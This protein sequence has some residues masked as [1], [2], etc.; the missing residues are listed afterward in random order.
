MVD[1]EAG[2]LESTITQKKT[3]EEFKAEVKD[4]VENMIVSMEN[5]RLQLKNMVHL[6]IAY[7][8]LYG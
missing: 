5:E 6:L 3:S 1:S 4:Q 2:K 8:T 7:I